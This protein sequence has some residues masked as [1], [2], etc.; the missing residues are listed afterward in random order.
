MTMPA[1][2]YQLINKVVQ[3]YEVTRTDT[4]RIIHEYLLAVAPSWDADQR[5]IVSGDIENAVHKS[6]AANQTE[7][8]R[9][10][11]DAMRAALKNTAWSDLGDRD[12][13]KL[14]ALAP[15]IEPLARKDALSTHDRMMMRDVLNDFKLIHG[16]GE[17]IVEIFSDRIN[18]ERNPVWPIGRDSITNSV[19]KKRRN[20]RA[21]S[22]VGSLVNGSMRCIGQKTR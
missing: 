9:A 21:T 4:A 16:D 20:S 3:D 19:S 11:R 13:G 10:L 12:P 17:H 15:L 22:S 14:H 1:A 7:I 18:G 2:V 8:D 6:L 5:W